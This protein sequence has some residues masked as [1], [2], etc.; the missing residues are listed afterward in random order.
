VI[1][2]GQA[3]DITCTVF[4]LLSVLFGVRD[5]LDLEESYRDVIKLCLVQ[6]QL[7]EFS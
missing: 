7:S 2:V 6:V 3:P 1:K 4:E 5:C